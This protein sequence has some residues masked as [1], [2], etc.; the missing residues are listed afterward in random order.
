[1]ARADA[2][3]A[4]IEVDTPANEPSPLAPFG[5][6]AFAVLWTAT[7]VSNIGTWMQSAA[8][9]WLMTSLDP[10]PFSV[11]LVQVA[12][13]LPMFLF[14]LPAGALADIVDRRR[15]LIIIQV[16]VMIL[17][18]VFG[19][20][21]HLT[22]V[23]PTLL[24]TFTFVA[25]AAAASITP[26]WQAIVPQLVPRRHLPPAVALNSVGLNVSRAVGPALAGIMISAWGIAAPF[27]VNAL[28]TIAVIAALIWW[29]PRED[30]AGRRLP[31]ERFHRAI[32]AGL[33]HAR[34]NPH[35]R[36]TL[37]RASGFFLFASAYWALLPLLAH[38]QVAGGP[39]IYGVLLG[40]IGAGA[41]AGAFGLPWLTHRLG[42]D[43]LVALGTVGTV[44][45]LLLFALARSWAIALAGSVIAGMSWIMV[46]ATINV[47]AQV[48]LPGWVRGR[49][50]SIFGTVMFGSLTI[51]SAVWGK[52]ATF[53]GLPTAHILAG[54]GALIA[55][56]LLWRWK[57]QTGAVLDLTPSMH[58][59]TP[60]LRGDVG[61]DQGPVLV[62]VEYQIK[63][64]DR[65][66][67]LQAL[68][69]LGS[70][71]RRDGAFEWEAFE[72]LS[73]QGRFLETF[74]L[75]SWLEHLRQH[76]RVTHADREQ[77]ELVHRFQ[78]DG[79]PKVSHLIGASHQAAPR[80]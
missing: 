10:A 76:E 73:E 25:A 50:L 1:M 59:P 6:R 22:W 79:K 15:L 30:G 64:T 38:D 61:A 9:G 56:P 60:V 44:V 23:T 40:A 41:V 7:V 3:S 75:D 8:A 36:A 69:R 77:Q 11:S 12:S 14:G 32:G 54:F 19:L 4:K 45:A 18:A 55:V 78:L 33:R 58:W 67:F 48:A 63:P 52:V 51:G 20:M 74:K 16:T 71:R 65:G 47:S 34:Y 37:I 21:V 80:G 43:R 26:A 13:S 29:H 72:D 27:W 31:A 28:T 39:E 46:L 57:L 53:G 49:G 42:P 24:L 62:T 5:D 17:V 35:L 2:E 70:E 68:E 66:P